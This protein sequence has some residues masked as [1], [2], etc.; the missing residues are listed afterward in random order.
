MKMKDSSY[1]TKMAIWL[2][3]VVIFVWAF[4]PA[5]SSA[6]TV[7]GFALYWYGAASDATIDPNLFIEVLDK[8]EP[9]ECFF[10]ICS[11]DVDSQY[12]DPNCPD[13]LATPNVYD[14][15]LNVGC[16]HNKVNQAYVWGLAKSG[17]DLWFGTAPNTHCLV[18]GALGALTGTLNPT[19]NES[20][21]CEFGNTQYLHPLVGPLPAPVGDWR[22]PRIFLYKGKEEVL[23]EKTADLPFNPHLLRLQA[24]TGI[25]SAGKLG[26]VVILG[27]PNLQNGINLFAFNTE[28]G[29]FIS[30]TTLTEYDNIRKWLVVNGVLY[31]TVGDTGGG[32]SVLRWQGDSINPFQFDVVGNLDS[33]GAELAYHEGRL[34]VSTWPEIG[35]GGRAALWMS[36]VIPEGGLTEA[37]KFDGDPLDPGNPWKKVWDVD[38]Y[39]PDQVTAAT[40]GGGAL[41]SFDGYLYWGTMHVPTAATAIHTAF[42][43]TNPFTQT[44]VGY[45]DLVDGIAEDKEV[46]AFLGTHRAITIFR[47]R[48][49]Q[50]PP[51]PSEIQLVYGMEQLPVFSATPTGGKWINA[52]WSIVDNNM[53]TAPLY[54]SSGFG[55]IFN[56][57]TWTM[58][59]FNDELYVGTMDFA[60]LLEGTDLGQPEIDL[61]DIPGFS[62]G[63]DL[64]R[65]PSSDSQAIPERI[66]GVG[67]FANY[68]IRT[69]ISDDALY[70]GMANP[71]NLLTNDQGVNIGGW[72]LIK[73]QVAT[74]IGPVAPNDPA[75][76][77]DY[78]AGIQVNSGDL[79]GAKIVYDS[80][81]PVAPVFG[82]SDEVPPLDEEGMN[83]V[84]VPLNLQ[85][86]GTV[87]NTPVK[88]FIPCPPP[89]IFVDSLRVY[90]HDGADWVFVCGPNGIVAPG[91]EDLYV[92]GSRANHNDTTPPTIEVH[93][94]HFTGVQAGGPIAAI[95]DDP[96]GTGTT[97]VPSGDSGGGGGC[98]IKAVHRLST[99]MA[100]LFILGLIAATL[101]AVWRTRRAR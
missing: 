48:N 13:S 93:L 68:G 16:D 95:G 2:F 53:G 91:A 57:Y 67:N 77:G 59:V 92:S 73:L 6:E 12:Y 66:Q 90:L 96:A 87:F 76:G 29:D 86:S 25:R 83:A 65:F 81:E 52:T 11:S 89:Y 28:T 64:F 78:D 34:F 32:G 38:E 94:Y 80:S 8:A 30:S 100:G 14:P 45:P 85:P 20:W 49:F 40:Y 33:Q 55:N 101:A 84:G 44:Q 3:I 7:E 37:H 63:A 31:T 23:I 26:N 24:S 43:S 46:K 88:V 10:G 79:E 82:P 35:E 97:T 15:Y 17:N 42:Y 69:M 72:E 99:G 50:V 18:T 22:P 21:V 62:S 74:E 75:L 60:Y 1:P 71:M 54:G 58:S 70:L 4:V 61:S 27:G 9:D 5:P 56:N 98:F 47:G 39:E 36:P 41:A 51:A 19:W